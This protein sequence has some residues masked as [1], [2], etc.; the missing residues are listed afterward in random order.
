MENQVTLKFWKPSGKKKKG[1]TPTKKVRRDEVYN[2]KDSERKKK[3][4]HMTSN[5]NFLPEDFDDKDKDV[6]VKTKQFLKIMDFVFQE[7]KGETNL[8]QQSS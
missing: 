1:G 5:N 3:F 8:T 4:R 2:F 6:S 7:N